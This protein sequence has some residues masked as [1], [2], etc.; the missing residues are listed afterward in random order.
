MEKVILI[1]G[2]T[3]FVGQNLVH[4]IIETERNSKLVLL[5]R[6]A[7]Q[8]EA[9]T[10][11]EKILVNVFKNSGFDKVRRRIHIVKGDVSEQNLGL[12]TEQYQRLTRDV[13][14]IIHSAAMTKFDLSLAEARTINCTGTKNVMDF[15]RHALR[16]G[17]L[18]KIAHIS[19]AFVSGN[20]SG[21]IYEDELESTGHFSNTYEQ[22]KFESEQMIRKLYN[23]LPVII[24]RPSII[25][26]HSK[27]GETTNFNVLYYTMKLLY[28]GYLKV[29]PGWKDVLMGV[30][31]I[32]FVCDAIYH[33]MLQT[34]ITG[35][36]TYHL[37]A[38]S[39]KA[40]T[41]SELTNLATCYF[42]LM[43]K[44]RQVAN[45]IFL[46]PKMVAVLVKT[47]LFFATNIR[48]IVN[49]YGPYL[50]VKRVFDNRDAMQI[51]TRANIRPPVLTTY[52]ET[53]L[54]YCLKSDWGKRM[55]AVA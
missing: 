36:K 22:S 55:G 40:M 8:N 50:A 52:L 16:S 32:D 35:N 1:T 37:T 38:G 34:S 26:G 7:T 42:N 12:T 21:I 18:I 2:A 30:V 9:V 15:A 5:V 11:M 45:A 19:T 23:D 6:G 51:L 33:I 49:I 46:P 4:K 48:K 53:I 14:H 10:R 44:E 54:G 13:T 3:G 39:D 28:R 25:V 41:L 27:T 31:P 20:R 17:K 29:I 43:S 24:F 47:L